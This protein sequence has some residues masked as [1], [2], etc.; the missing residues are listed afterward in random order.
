MPVNGIKGQ[1]SLP[2]NP[3]KS[4]Q[5]EWEAI[6]KDVTEGAK[7]GAK[8]DAAIICQGAALLGVK[9]CGDKPVVDGLT[10]IVMG[11]S[12][13]LAG[14]ASRTYGALKKLF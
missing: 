14:G 7:A 6:K 10:S 8:I 5:T 2:Q 1:Q 12:Y 4:E 9:G 11:A 3:R 13:G